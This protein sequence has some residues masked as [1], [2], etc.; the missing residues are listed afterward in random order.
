MPIG[1]E[2]LLAR[3]VREVHEVR[4]RLARFEG[5]MEPR[6]ARKAH[7]G[8][9][10]GSACVVLMGYNAHGVAECYFAVRRRSLHAACMVGDA[11]WRCDRLLWHIRGSFGGPSR[12]ALRGDAECRGRGTAR[13]SRRGGRGSDSV[14]AGTRVSHETSARATYWTCR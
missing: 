7:A 4:E 8:R 3:E 5:R 1:R 14:R 12:A 10:T 6:M 13:G 9:A 2:R 11:S